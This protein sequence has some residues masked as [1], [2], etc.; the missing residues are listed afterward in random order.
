MIHFTEITS[1][2]TIR[3]L[4]DYL[5]LGL[6]TTGPDPEADRILELGMVRVADGEVVNRAGTLVSPGMPIPPEVTEATGISDLVV[7]S[8]PGYEQMADSL[9]G[10]LAGGVL[11]TDKADLRFLRALLEGSESEGEI[12]YVNLRRLARSLLPD[13]E[14][15]SLADLASCF[16]VPL[17]DNAR[18]LETADARSQ[19]FRACVGRIPE[20]A[21]ASDKPRRSASGLI[22]RL[23]PGSKPRPR[24]KKKASRREPLS[25]EDLISLVSAIGFLVLA[26][27]FLPSVSSLLLLL[28]AVVIVPLPVWR[29]QLDR[30]HLNGWKLTAIAAALFVLALVIHPAS[31][32]AEQKRAQGDAV[33]SY[34]ILSWDKAGSYGEEVVVEPEDGSSPYS[35]MEFHIPTGTYRVLNNGAAS[36]KVA[37]YDNG[38]K[39]DPHAQADTLSGESNPELTI[40][41]NKSK[42]ITVQEEQFVTLSEKSENVIFQYLEPLPEVIED[43]NN[44]VGSVEEQPK[45]Y[46]YVNGTE[47]RLRKTASVSGFIMGTFDTGKQV[48]V[49]GV[50]GDW[51]AVIVDDQVGYIYSTYLSDTDPTKAG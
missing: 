35:Y 4:R 34:I 16:D 41:G 23:F 1:L 51:T 29:R 32:R 26:V 9:A 49:T 24:K 11:I 38:T 39:L 8:A 22:Y 7:A 5:V 30:F 15:Y 25:T 27:L 20:S 13:L 18:A 40:L 12:R 48:Q 19:I 42:E 21:D 45:V 43:E 33:P 3:S 10:L 2:K 46:A 17:E 44:T 14:S 37:V 50:V 6:E 31:V 36:V 47:V 28:A